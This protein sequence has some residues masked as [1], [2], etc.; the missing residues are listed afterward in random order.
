[1]RVPLFWLKEF[2]DIDGYSAKELAYLLSIRGIEAEASTIG[3]RVNNIKIG[4][5]EK[6]EKH[7]NADKLQICQVNVGNEVLQI[8]TG[9]SNVYEGMLVPV[10]LI[11]AD[12]GEGFKIKKAKLRGVESFG[13]LCSKKELGFEEESFGIWDLKKEGVKEKDIGK[14]F[15]EVV[16]LIDVID[17]EITPNRPDALSVRGIARELSPI[18]EREFRDKKIEEKENLN[19][20]NNRVE[21]RDTKANPRYAYAIIKNVKIGPSPSWLVKKLNSVGANSINNIVDI[22]NLVLFEL[23]HPMHAFD[24]DKLDGERIIVDWAKDGEEILAL[25]SYTYKLDSSILTIRDEKK[26]VAIAG[27]IGGE[28][29]AISETTTNILLECAYF[30]PVVIRRGSKK[31][32]V[33]TDSSYRFERGI[34]PNGVKKALSYAID[35]ILEVAGGEVIEIG[36][37]YP[38]KIE[39]KEVEFDLQELRERID[40]DI[41][42]EKTE[43]ILKG[44][45]F[46]ILEKKI[47]FYKVKIPTFRVDISIKEDIYEEIARIYGYENIESK[48]P[49][50]GSEYISDDDVFDRKIYDIKKSLRGLGLREIYTTTLVN[51]RE[52]EFFNYYNLEII[53]L[54]NS[55]TKGMTHLRTSMLPSMLKIAEHNIHHYNDDFRL[56]EFGFIYGKD[57]REDF[58]SKEIPVLGVIL[59]GKRFYL[60]WATKD[61]EELDYF[62]VKGIL[63]GILNILDLDFTQLS[64]NRVIL[65]GFDLSEEI[66]LNGRVIGII[67]RLSSDILEEYDIEKNIFFFEI[68][69]KEILD[70]K[71]EIKY[72]PIPKFPIVWRDLAF[73]VPFSIPS[74]KVRETILKN[75]GPYIY[76][77]EEVDYYESEKLGK[78]VR[79]ISYRMY[80]KPKDKTFTDKEI[81]K[82]F[83]NIIKACRKNLNIDL[84]I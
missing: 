26:P 11:G 79:S 68:F 49:F 77:V 73:I 48:L 16:G 14:D 50:G 57:E 23:N 6:L 29:S 36:D 17:I 30:D 45:G 22:T 52:A 56:F 76:K 83:E 35:L 3:K 38:E 74:E 24:F 40:I 32:G 60:N 55:L 34:D 19:Y 65:S 51:K 63:E 66:L 37:I 61:K 82:Y 9:A 71:K 44:L 67:G 10:A 27:I 13:M 59:S 81:D 5:I 15:Y 4:K 75:G 43:N 18:I 42:E 1:M 33:S 72:E 2:I 53:E 12:F 39:E 78:N 80:F 8:V 84:R 46:S 58:Y 62:D 64:Y 69:Y 70:N 20:H 7:P 47:S 41:T 54:A 31:L 21:V 28:V 25:N